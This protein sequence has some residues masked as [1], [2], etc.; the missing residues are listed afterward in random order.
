MENLLLKKLQIKPGFKVSVLNAPDNFLPLIGHKP[1][2]ITFLFPASER[3]DALL[4]FATTKAAMLEAIR[5]EQQHIGA[6]T[7]F[8]IL[9][10]K[11]KT[12]LAG[13][14]NLMQSWDELK[15]YNLN[16][17]A[18]AAIDSCWTALRIK[19]IDQT[20]K[21]GLGNAEIQQK[22]YG[23]YIDVKAKT[24]TLPPDLKNELIKNSR[25]LNFYEQ[26]SYSN[27][28]EYVLWVLT[29]KQEKTRTDRI[30]KTVDKLLSG[31]KNPGEK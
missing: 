17:C 15:T 14:L 13:D 6:D 26:L 10:P 9:Y 3:Y 20:K 22:D 12:K 21:S 25:A 29:A 4:L 7:I 1:E 16:P 5:R 27:R 30:R 8:W 23:N 24:V 28:K 18:A 2:E 19:T 11:A 31:K